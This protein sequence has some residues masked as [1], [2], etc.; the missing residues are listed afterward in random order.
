MFLDSIKLNQSKIIIKSR[1][2]LTN[3]KISW[4]CWVKWKISDINK[5]VYVF[6][7]F[8]LDKSCNKK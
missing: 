4:E 8:V 1:E 5:N 3:V 7:I 6:D 2:D